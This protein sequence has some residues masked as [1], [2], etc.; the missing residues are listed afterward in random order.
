MANILFILT[1]MEEKEMAYQD[2]NLSSQAQMNEYERLLGYD[3]ED[4][5]GNKIGSV[6]TVWEDHTGQP[7]FLGISTGWLGLGKIHV[8]PAHYAT[9]TERGKR[10]RIPF[11]EDVIKSAPEFESDYDFTEEGESRLYEYYRGKGMDTSFY[12]RDRSPTETADMGR[13][14]AADMDTDIAMRTDTDYD[15]TRETAEPSDWSAD[16]TREADIRT[17][18]AE[19]DADADRTKGKSAL[20]EAVD[21]A[22]N[23]LSRRG[24]GDKDRDVDL[25]GERTIPLSEERLNVQKRQV[26]AGGVRLRKI[27]RTETVNQPVELQHEEIEIERVP[28]SGTARPG[29]FQEEEIYVPLRREEVDVSK[30][31]QVREEVRVN[32]RTETERSQIKESLRKEDVE[33]DRDTREDRT[34]R[35]DK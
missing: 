30:D 33:V 12:D 2:E 7:A 14:P 1:D 35:L 10:I 5:D 29:D 20:G 26:E 32:K 27:I 23:A 28:A 6:K 13:S 9:Y 15:R 21:K 25:E 16:R 18:D 31:A 34:D 4:K 19:M 17:T 3:V 22:K 24:K 11:N 8:V